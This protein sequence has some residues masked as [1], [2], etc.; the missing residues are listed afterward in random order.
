M[1]LGSKIDIW[2]RILP[3][4]CFQPNHFVSTD[5]L[6]AALGEYIAYY[7]HTARPIKWT[8]TVEQLEQTLGKLF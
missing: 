4:K 6:E 8:S 2:C 7:N 5:A 1:P 3:R